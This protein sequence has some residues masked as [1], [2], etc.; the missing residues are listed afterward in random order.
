[1]ELK[2]CTPV[3]SLPRQTFTVDDKTPIIRIK[4]VMK[5]QG[6]NKTGIKTNTV[7]VGYIY[8][9]VGGGV[10]HEARLVGQRGMLGLKSEFSIS[11]KVALV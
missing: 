9:I 10:Y 4:I 6:C 3:S 5:L 11:Q 8:F 1:M 2:R 7:D